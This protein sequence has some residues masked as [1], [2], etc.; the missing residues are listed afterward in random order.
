MLTSILKKPTHSIPENTQK[1]NAEFKK[2]RVLVTL[3]F[4]F[5][6]GSG[7][8][9]L[10]SLIANFSS[11][12]S[13]NQFS[14]ITKPQQIQVE[15]AARKLFSKGS[16]HFR[17]SKL[18]SNVLHIFVEI[19]SP[20]DLSVPQQKNYIRQSVCPK[21]GNQVWKSVNS[22]QVKL[23]LITKWIKYKATKQGDIA[24]FCG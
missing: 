17:E 18:M 23:H 9:F 13:N 5:I 10:L 3:C 8:L 12:Y 14:E 24:A 4:V 16:W 15:R 21:L 20:L 19:P 7:S 22:K 1:Q 2:R 11:G 6:Y